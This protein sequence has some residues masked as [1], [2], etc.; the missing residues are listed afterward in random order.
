[1]D[2]YGTDP[3]TNQHGTD[4]WNCKSCFGQILNVGQQK[5][6]CGEKIIGDKGLMAK[7]WRK[8]IVHKA[9]NKI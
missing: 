2:Q 8:H 3:C 6:N 5:L 1:M 7:E 4:T 9:K